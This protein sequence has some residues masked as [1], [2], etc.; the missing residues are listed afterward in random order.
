MNIAQISKRIFLLLAVNILVMATITLVL[1]CC[2]WGI[3]SPKAA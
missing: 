1:A 3:T 2:T